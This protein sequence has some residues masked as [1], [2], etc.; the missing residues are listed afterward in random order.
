MPK[1]SGWI[2]IGSNY[3]RGHSPNRVG[4]SSVALV[5]RCGVA[6]SRTAKKQSVSSRAAV[7]GA[8]KPVAITAEELDRKFDNGENIDAYIDWSKARRPGRETFKVNVDFPLDLLRRIDAE[9]TRIGI[10][11]QAWIKLRLTD[12]LDQQHASPETAA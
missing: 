10:A 6:L 1:R 4:R 3:R 8:Q 11:R 5:E 2:R 7:R 12:L 9:A